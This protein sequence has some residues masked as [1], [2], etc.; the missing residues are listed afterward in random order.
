MTSMPLITDEMVNEFRNMG[1][2]R[3]SYGR[4][5]IARIA[6]GSVK[7]QQSAECLM[8]GDGAACGCNPATGLCLGTCQ[9]HQCVPT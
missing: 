1:R 2:H 3:S 9:G 8:K 7:L 4:K 6:R 5:R